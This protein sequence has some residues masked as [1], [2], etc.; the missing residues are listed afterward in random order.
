M[1]DVFLSE[2]NSMSSQPL[3][4]VCIPSYNNES[5]I[6]AT[7]DSI[8][9]QTYA[10]FE[11]IV[12]DDYSSDK[13]VSLVKN[14]PDSRI[15]LIQNKTNLGLAGNWNIALSHATGKYVKVLGADD[16]LYPN[17]LECQVQALEDPSN[18]GPVLAVCNTD[19]INANNRIILRRRGRF[20]HGVVGGAKLIRNCV[21]WGANLIGEP[22]VGLFRRD[23]LTKSGMF[24]PSNP[25]MIDLA[26][27]AEVLKHG[28]AFMDHRRLAAF[29]ISQSSVS[30]RLGLEQ[31]VYTRSVIR[32]LRADRVYRI[33]M[34]DVMLGYFFAFPRCVFRNFL[35]KVWGGS[36]GER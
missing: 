15:T 33:S 14:V 16:L 32:K 12:T 26:F 28:N 13:T 22:V 24:D 8:L 6:A 4:S 18:S 1:N 3:I 30:A 2:S 9:K 17:C 5:F 35:I 34:L 25:Y 21:R 7:L 23:V 19:V 31:A 20:G 27:W 36:Q 10:H 11:I 29:R